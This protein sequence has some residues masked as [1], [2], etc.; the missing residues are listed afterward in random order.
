MLLDHMKHQD[1]ALLA[2]AEFM[3]ASVGSGLWS[4]VKAGAEAAAVGINGTVVGARVGLGL[5][6]LQRGWVG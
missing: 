3:G 5:Y 1:P 2:L 6:A 4:W